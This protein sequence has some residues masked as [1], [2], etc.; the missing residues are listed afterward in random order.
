MIKKL[1][2]NERSR[3]FKKEDIDFS[4]QNIKSREDLKLEEEYYSAKTS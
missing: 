2:F 1:G 4:Y 3:S